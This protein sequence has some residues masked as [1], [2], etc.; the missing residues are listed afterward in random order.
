MLM[1]INVYD[2]G[3]TNWDASEKLSRTWAVN[4]SADLWIVL[5]PPG[6]RPVGQRSREIYRLEVRLPNPDGM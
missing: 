5:P 6:V 2:G 3:E 4:H 1:I